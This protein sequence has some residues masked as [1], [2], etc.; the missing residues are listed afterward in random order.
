M[1]SYYICA[2]I[3][4]LSAFT[5]L[6]FSLQAVLSAKNGQTTALYAASRSIALAIVSLLPL[7]GHSTS[8][9]SAIAITM[10]IVQGVDAGI[11]FRIKSRL[12]AYGPLAT[13]LFNLL[14]LIWLL[15]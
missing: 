13:A 3:T 8:F 10:I 5:S 1:V 7:F 15:N 2:S 11:G 12:K 14:A 6:G 9:L 4:A